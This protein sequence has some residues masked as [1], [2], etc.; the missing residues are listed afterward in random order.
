MQDNN[1]TIFHCAVYN[2]NKLFY[3]KLAQFELF[4]HLS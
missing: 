3:S 2:S 4:N 1:V